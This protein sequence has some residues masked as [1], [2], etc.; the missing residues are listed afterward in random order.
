[1]KGQVLA[2]MIWQVDI[3]VTPQL[4]PQVIL[5]RNQSHTQSHTECYESDCEE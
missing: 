2:E 4:K 1:M 5:T 3:R